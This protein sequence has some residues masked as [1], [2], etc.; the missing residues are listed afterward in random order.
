MPTAVRFSSSSLL[1]IALRCAPI[2]IGVA[3][4]CTLGIV[5]IYADNEIDGQKQL[6]FLLIGTGL[7][8]AVQLA[9]YAAIGRLAWAFYLLSIGAL[10]YTVLP[11]V[12]S[13]GFLGVP[14]VNGAKAWIEFGIMRFQPAEV[15]KLAFVIVLARY[16]RYR[17]NY[18]SFTGL[19]APFL[20]AGCPL[21]LIL[22]QPD[23]GTAL[24]FI[25]ALFTMLFV[26]GAR[27]SHLAAIIG[28]GVLAAPL[29][30]LSGQPG[31]PVFQ[32]LPSVVK[33]YQRARVYAMF[34][35]DPATLQRTGFQQ[36]NALIALGSGGFT[37]KGA[38]NILV[39]KRVPERHN[40][41]IFALIGEQFGFLG[42]SA[43]LFAY[44]LIFFAGIEIA[45]STKDPSG[46]LVAVGLT[47]L[48]AGQTFL[49]MAVALKLFPVTGV[50]LP[51]V[52]YGGSSL[53]ASIT[54]AGLLINISLH[55]PII[56][57]KDLFESDA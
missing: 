48:L 41:M 1:L 31:V 45:G 44:V 7:L 24:V 53:L 20:L 19:I 4:L 2:M 25:P 21:L 6:F 46:R 54:A 57:G 3:I 5:S 23:L 26:A 39:G 40:D 35:D 12:P 18:R 38:G 47:T 17:E 27:T 36:H 11:G 49:N 15:T 56:M 14:T 34:S 43:L 28:A 13:S 16:L 37:G 55:R 8:L 33:E 50:T 10:L 9:S 52:S 42:V 29:L 32:H 30:W 51:F 22:K